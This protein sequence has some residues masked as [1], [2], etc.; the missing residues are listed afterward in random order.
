[1]N[2]SVGRTIVVSF[3]GTGNEP[4]DIYECIA[5]AAHR[6]GRPVSHAVGNLRMRLYDL[7]RHRTAVPLHWIAT[8]GALDSKNGSEETR[9]GND[10]HRKK[11]GPPHDD[12]AWWEG[13]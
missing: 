8:K 6:G 1:M 7:L 12:S 4:D 10:R 5:K 11:E 9:A 13:R 2:A 3:D